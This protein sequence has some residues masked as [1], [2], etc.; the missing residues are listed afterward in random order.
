VSV[1]IALDYNEVGVC[2]V[3]GYFKRPV[4]RTRRRWTILKCFLGKI[5]SRM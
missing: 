2:R 3:E 1:I 5:G 4:V